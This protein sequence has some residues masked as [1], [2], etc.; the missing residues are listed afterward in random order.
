MNNDKVWKWVCCTSSKIL[1]LATLGCA[2][3]QGKAMIGNGFVYLSE[4]CPS[5]VIAAS[6]ATAE[7]FTGTVVD[8]YRRVEAV[9]S[10][11]GAKALCKVQADAQNLGLSLKIFDAYRPVKAVEYFV[12][13]SKIPGD[14]PEIKERYYPTHTKAELFDLGYIARQSSHSRGSAVDLTLVDTQGVELDMGT[15]FDYFHETSHTQNTAIT[16]AQKKNRE[17]LVSLMARH[18]FRNYAKEWWHFSLIKEA[19]PG[20]SFDFD[21]E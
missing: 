15:V 13:W 17:L 1:I 4:A 12:S 20:R 6:Y 14:I 21:I 10:E 3:F 5:L 9:Y 8:G 11:V 19:F 7:N 16:V 2:S 18:G